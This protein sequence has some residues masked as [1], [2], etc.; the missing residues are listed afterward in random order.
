MT[1]KILYIGIQETKPNVACATTE[2]HLD[3]A[4]ACVE[5]TTSVQHTNEGIWNSLTWWDFPN[6]IR[7]FI[8]KAIHNAYKCGKYWCN[9]QGYKQRG[10]CQVCSAEENIYYVLIECQTS[11]QELIWALVKELL[12]LCNLWFTKP[13][14]GAILGCRLADYRSPKDQP[15][16]RANR[17]HALIVSESAHL[18]WKIRGDWKI[19]LGVT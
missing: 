15:L 4:R 8:W 7:N 12:A 1:Q 18:I 19:R 9:I 11:G 10:D 13:R 3:I 2:I 17:L 14:F 16:T 5:E 6:W